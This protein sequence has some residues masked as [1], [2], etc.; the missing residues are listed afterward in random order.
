MWAFTPQEKR[1]ILFLLITLLVGSGILVYKKYNPEFAP[2]LLRVNSAKEFSSRIAG[3]KSF[4][5]VSSSVTLEIPPQKPPQLFKL[6]LNTATQEELERIPKI[7]PVLARRIIDY[8]YEKGGFDSIEEIM[9]VK[10][11]GKKNF[12]VIKD[13]LILE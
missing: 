11:I 9:E 2:E 12:A 3:T 13:Y 6:N 7:G 8:R 10:G 4:S 1:A 5:S